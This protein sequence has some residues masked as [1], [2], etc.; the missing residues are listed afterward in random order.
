MADAAESADA[1]GTAAAEESEQAPMASPIRPAMAKGS[2]SRFAMIFLGMLAIFALIDPGLSLA[3]GDLAGLVLN[4][5]IGFGGGFPV[6]TILLAGMLTTSISSL[7]RHHYTDWVK[8]MRSNKVMA[9]WR[10]ENMEALRKGNQSKIQK[11]KAI[12][13]NLMKD[14]MDVQFAPMKSMAWTFFFFIVLFVWLR[15]FV[16]QI[17]SFV[18]NQYIAVPWAP[19]VWL[20]SAYFFP[21]WMLLY[22]LLAIPFGQIVTRVLKYVRFRRKLESMGLPL[23]AEADQL[24]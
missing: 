16:D 18:G 3:F 20:E 14:S 7:L 4:P 6:I 5:L 15:V 13:Q 21:S 24:P 1:K 2:I 23:K 8:M 9:A 22:S 19:R 11:M 17:L 10:K 12:Q